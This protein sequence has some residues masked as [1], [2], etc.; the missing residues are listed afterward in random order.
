MFKRL[1]KNK[2]FLIGLTIV[3]ILIVYFF[4]RGGSATTIESAVVTAGD[5]IEKVSV[6]G[7]ISPVDKADLSFDTSGSISKIY[8]KVGD[9]VS[10]GDILASLDN[11]D[12]VASLASAQAKLDDLTRSLRPE[13]LQL[14]QSKVDIASA[15]FVNTKT[16]A[17][18]ASRNAYVQ[19]QGALVNYTDGFFTNSQS[20]NPTININ[21]QS[22]TTKS[23]IDFERVVAGDNLK[24]WKSNLDI[25]TSTDDAQVLLV[26]ADKSLTQVKTFMDDLSTI[27]NQLSPGNS[28]L[29][30]PIIDSYLSAMNAGLN[31]LNQAIASI[32]TAKTN[33]DQAQTGYTEAYSNFVLQKSGSSVESI[34]SQQATV[35]SLAAVVDKGTIY[36]PIDGIVTRVDP[37]EGEYTTPGI[38][39]FAVQSEGTYKIEA[40]V[41]EADIAKVAIGDNASVTLDA[42][43]SDTIFE[44]TVTLIDPAETVLEGVPT[45]KVTLQFTKKDIRI[46]SGMTA[47]TDILTH[48]HDSVL[49]IPTRAILINADGTK[50]VRIL[51]KDGKTFATTTIALGL[52]GSSGTTEIISGIKAGDHVVTYVK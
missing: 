12:T 5:V 1:F 50:S 49:Y 27:V 24:S 9:K 34:R 19:T 25:S 35:D 29:Q 44:A 21:T 40:Y 31:L 13:E 15:N 46:R 32:S 38:S 14:E 36:S 33:L 11:A 18:N 7:K 42:Y 10:K 17:I 37:H 45:Y 3:V 16:A 2:Y 20:A 51:N 30:Q 41:P 4:L 48:E 52:K 6:T 28:G 26:D 8:V 43:G 39:G 47:N 23:A 22:N